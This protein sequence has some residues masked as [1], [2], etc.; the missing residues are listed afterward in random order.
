MNE[1]VWKKHVYAKELSLRPENNRHVMVIYCGGTVGMKY[2]ESQG[3]CT[4][5]VVLSDMQ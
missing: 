1:F 5:Y 3:V 4:I 2:I